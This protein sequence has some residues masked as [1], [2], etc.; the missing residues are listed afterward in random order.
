MRGPESTRRDSEAAGLHLT[1][2]CVTFDSSTGSRGSLCVRN[3]CPKGHTQNVLGSCPG[4][5]I[6]GPGAQLASTVAVD[7]P[8]CQPRQWS[9]INTC[10]GS[11]RSERSR[12]SAMP[13]ALTLR[14]WNEAAG[15][16][17]DGVR[18]DESSQ[19][20]SPAAKC[21]SNLVS[22][23]TPTSSASAAQQ[24]LAGV[25]VASAPLRARA[26]CPSRRTGSVT[27]V[28]RREPRSG[29]VRAGL[30]TICICRLSGCARCFFDGLASLQTSERNGTEAKSAKRKWNGVERL[31]SWRVR[32]GRR[33]NSADT[34]RKARSAS[35]RSVRSV[36]DW[37][38]CA[39]TATI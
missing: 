3:K 10:A 5:Q 31:E 35:V 9:R 15:W 24:K 39:E 38:P 2:F 19:A 26:C 13:L 27:T 18:A 28:R 6:G 20:R 7:G 16:P 23:V 8:P 22:V 21:Q 1:P 11:V 17:A 14:R 12:D 33:R 32:H 37:P 34:W 30:T 25:T 4:E 29:E 36:P